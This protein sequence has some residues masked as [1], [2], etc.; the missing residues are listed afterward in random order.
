MR[1]TVDFIVTNLSLALHAGFYNRPSQFLMLFG[2]VAHLL[3]RIPPGDLGHRLP[4]RVPL[5]HVDLG[6]ANGHLVA[7]GEAVRGEEGEAPPNW[8]PFVTAASG[9]QTTRMPSRAPRF[10]YTWDALLDRLP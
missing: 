1:S 3:H 4:D 5:D 10:A 2:V 7:L 8:R 9:G 6:R